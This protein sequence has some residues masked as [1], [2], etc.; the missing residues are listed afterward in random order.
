MHESATLSLCWT[1]S[2]VF[3]A[4]PKTTH[5]LA[6]VRT[7]TGTHSRARGVK[8]LLYISRDWVNRVCLCE[9]RQGGIR[10]ETSRGGEGD[11][12]YQPRPGTYQW[13]RQRKVAKKFLQNP[14]VDQLHT[15]LNFLPKI[16]C[17]CRKIGF[18]EQFT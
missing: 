8:S 5:A 9:G 11:K 16:N 3:V 14:D 7:H 6:H 17:F 10:R 13:H 4:R 12:K 18:T 15:C 1:A 2:S